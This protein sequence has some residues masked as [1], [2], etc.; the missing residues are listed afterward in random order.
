MSRSGKI[1][2]L[3]LVF[4]FVIIASMAGVI[5]AKVISTMPIGSTVAIA[6]LDVNQDEVGMVNMLVIG[7]D[8]DG[9]RSDT[10]MLFSLDGY[11]HRVNVLSFQRDTRVLLNGH[12]QKLN[13]AMGIGIQNVKSGKCKEPEEVLIQEIK[14]LSGLPIHYFVT[15]DFDGFK[16]IINALGGVDFNVPYNM[17]YDDPVQNL[18]IHL[19]AGQQHLDGQAAHDFVR[20]RHN[21]DGSAPGEYVMGD[22]GRIYW[23]QKFVREL[24]RQ[25]AQP[26]YFAKIT[27]LFEVVQKNV[28]TN[29]TMNDLLKHISVLQNLD[30]GEVGTYKAPGEFAY[31]DNLWWYIQD[32]QKTKQLVQEVFLPRTREQWD[33]EQSEK[34]TAQALSTEAN[35]ATGKKQ[36]D[37]PSASMNMDAAPEPTEKK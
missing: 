8:E 21:N 7:V 6:G 15:I 31:M 20:Y 37:T 33:K 22:D 9:T 34:N 27:D 4:V 35:T 16:E 12:H 14:R 36:S 23:Q 32:E 17:N 1:T 11:S 2:A 19:K 28:R 26:Q 30:P 13:S 5:A 25:K 24:L 18:H 10:I 29:Y 3:I